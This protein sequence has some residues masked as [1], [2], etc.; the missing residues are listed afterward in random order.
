MVRVVFV[1]LSVVG[2]GNY[3]FRCT[4]SI[5]VDGKTELMC[6]NMF[7]YGFMTELLLYLNF[8]IKLLKCY[9]LK[10]TIF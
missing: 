2:G 10:R 1:L 9:H 8:I 6:Q 5:S 7:L 3:L 4:A